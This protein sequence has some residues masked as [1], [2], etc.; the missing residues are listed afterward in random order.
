MQLACT[1][2]FSGLAFNNCGCVG[3]GAWPGSSSVVQALILSVLGLER[4]LNVQV[5]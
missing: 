5:P 1:N 2:E 3:K 4:N